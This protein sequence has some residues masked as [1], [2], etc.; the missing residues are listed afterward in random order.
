MLLAKF[1]FRILITVELSLKIDASI[2]QDTNQYIQGSYSD[3]T[4]VWFGSGP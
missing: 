3:L 2:Q 4:K 1:L